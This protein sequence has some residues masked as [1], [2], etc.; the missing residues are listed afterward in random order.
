MKFIISQM[1]YLV[2]QQSN[3]RNVIYMLKFLVF[4]IVLVTIYSI[5]FHY[6]MELEGRYF[7]PVTGFYWTLT[8]MST[9]GFGDITFNEDVGKAFTIVVLLSGVLF[10]ML[11]MPFT[12]IRCIY[13]PWLDAQ[14][15]AITPKSLPKET[16]GHVIIVGEDDFA[17]AI[18]R[19]LREYA[20]PYIMLVP[21]SQKALATYD[22]G[23]KVV[24][25]PI[26][27]PS[28]YAAIQAEQ[29]SLVIAL[30]DD[31]KNTNI[32]STVREVAPTVPL[33]A[34][35]HHEDSYDILR[36]A[37][38]NNVYY[39]AQML[40]KFLARR[41]FNANSSAN[42]IGRF[43][44]FCIAEAPA[45]HTEL[46]GKSLIT[47]N[48]RD[49]FGL[50]VVGIWQG[51]EYMPALPDTIIDESAVLLLAGTEEAISKYDAYRGPAENSKQQPVVILGGG[52][53]SA[54]VAKTLDER[55]IPYCVVEK[56]GARIPANDPRYIHGSAADKD[57]LQRAGITKTETV[58][59]T[60]HD[61]D[62]NIYLTIYCR[63]LRPDIQII[64]RASLDRNVAS[65]YSAGANLVMSQSSMMTTTLV[66]LLIPG[67][68]FMLTEGL[69][70]FRVKAP[71]PL[72]GSTLLT[73][74]IR[75][76]T[77]CNVVAIRTPEGVSVPPDPLAVITKDVELI[78]IGSAESEIA[79]MHR[80]GVAKNSK[81]NTKI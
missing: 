77:E 79:F 42:I 35:I 73:S 18:A 20:L 21:D 12:F 50:N 75:K 69:N 71:T 68:V 53:V 47:A 29:A 5:L 34:R 33:A 14:S 80:Y 11:V 48:L 25:G 16:K 44:G 60:T 9:L 2:T 26:D 78:M 49:E 51:N 66:N 70:I 72:I 31:M 62:V 76:E 32:A 74:G 4:I 36:L 7:S 6:I 41:V 23:Y 52:T 28:T 55:G 37:G 63:K 3:R 56:N 10:F 67:R 15:K 19:G 30:H 46:V 64:S 1:A 24:V 8:V 58:V 27:L 65:L 13:S 22:A 61:D 17:K 45:Q 43:E 40:G 54:A 57:I 38:C 39:F 81:F 59:V